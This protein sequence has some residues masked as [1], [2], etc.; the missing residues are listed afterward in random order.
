MSG[1]TVFGERE[2]SSLQIVHV[3]MVRATRPECD[4]FKGPTKEGRQAAED[5]NP[6]GRKGTIHRRYRLSSPLF[7]VPARAISPL[8]TKIHILQS[9]PTIKDAPRY[10]TLPV[11]PYKSELELVHGH[12]DTLRCIFASVCS[13]LHEPQH[14]PNVHCL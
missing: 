6:I 9:Q 11:T 5:S 7:P 10:P 8:C 2:P 12:L 3:I 13:S 14:L 1:Y 4:P